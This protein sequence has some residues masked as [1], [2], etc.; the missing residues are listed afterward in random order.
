MAVGRQ[1]LARAD[2]AVDK[3]AVGAGVAHKGGV[4]KIAVVHRLPGRGGLAEVIAA[5]GG[6]RRGGCVGLGLVRLAAVGLLGVLAAGR[7][8]AAALAGGTGGGNAAACALA[9][10]GG[11]SRLSAGGQGQDDGKSGRKGAAELFGH[12]VVFSF[13]RYLF[14]S[15]ITVKL[16]PL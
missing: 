9:G 14:K 7:G 15:R 13:L 16:A 10:E 11:L 3:K 1:V 8:R 5:L 12:G 4:V 6:E 2:A